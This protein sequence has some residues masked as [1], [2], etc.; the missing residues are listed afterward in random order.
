MSQL[1]VALTLAVL[2]RYWKPPCASAG[3]PGVSRARLRGWAVTSVPRY[4]GYR[5]P[6]VAPEPF[7]KRVG[8]AVRSTGGRIG[9]HML[10]Q[11]SL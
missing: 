8:G 3:S 4:P 7:V 9:I 10:L 6:T 11:V 5:T 1:P 2:A